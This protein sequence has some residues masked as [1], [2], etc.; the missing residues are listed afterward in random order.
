MAKPTKVNRVK[1]KA[2]TC[3]NGHWHDAKHYTPHP[4]PFQSDVY[5]NDKFECVCCPK[6]TQDCA[7]DI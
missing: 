2:V 1:V 3:R 6:C 4:C 7:D 5:N